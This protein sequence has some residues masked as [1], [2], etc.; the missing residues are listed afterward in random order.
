[1]ALKVLLLRKRLEEKKIELE[2]V[3]AAA[4]AF[5]TRETELEQSIEEAQTDDEKTAVEG[6]VEQ[7]EIDQAANAASVKSLEGEIESIEKAI[8]EMERSQ[9]PPE[10][11]KKREDGKSMEMHIRS[12][13]FGM[14]PEQR[15]AFLARD[16]IKDFLQ[17]TRELGQQKRAVTGGELNIPETML[18]LIRE[19]IPKYS[20]LLKHV[21]VRPL[22]GKGRQNVVGTVP[23]AIWTEMY[24]TLNELDIYFNQIEM[25]GFKAGGFIVVPNALLE[26]SDLNLAAEIM[27]MLAQAIGIALDKAILYGKGT[28]MPLGIITRLAQAT[29]PSDY[30][31]KA[32]KWENLSVRNLIKIDSSLSDIKFFAAMV[33][34]AAKAKSKYSRGTDAKFWAMNEQTYAKVVSKGLAFNSAG[35]I[36]AQ[37]TGVL[38]VI[39][40]AV[41]LLDF[42]PDGDIVGG[43]GDLYVLAERAGTTLAQSEHVQFIEDNTVFKATARYDGKPAIPDGFVVINI[44]NK[45]PTTAID[46]PPDKANTAEEPTV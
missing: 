22:K 4:E 25:D 33:Q 44:D 28:K 7:F 36:V 46:F 21:R 31:A 10:A 39:G 6:L 12:N 16:D 27:S 41:E 1:M 32:P 30:P 2:K 34:E 15:G 26:D 14:N 43:Y 40:G 29:Q 20:K 9:K 45:A 19:T 17:R 3:R 23:E 5:E 24:G 11:S 18:E 8:E 38:P 35:A 13:F 37:S 42:I